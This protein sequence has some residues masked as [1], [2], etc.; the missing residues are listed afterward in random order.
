MRYEEEIER[1]QAAAGDLIEHAKAMKTNE[2]EIT[3]RDC[4]NGFWVVKARRYR[5]RQRNCSTWQA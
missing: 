4:D 3:L 2:V 1:G 5:P